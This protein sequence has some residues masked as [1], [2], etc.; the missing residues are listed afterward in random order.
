MGLGVD[1]REMVGL[2]SVNWTG[3]SL[4]TSLSDIYPLI[5]LRIWG[6][7]KRCSTAV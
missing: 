5:F 2:Y 7:R 6:M 1:E 4:C 3:S